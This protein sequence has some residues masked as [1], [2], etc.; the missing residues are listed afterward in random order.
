VNVRQSEKKMERER[1]RCLNTMGPHVRSPT[2]G[3]SKIMGCS[4][5]PQQEWTSIVSSPEIEHIFG[6]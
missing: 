3:Y 4:F 1:E 6:I 5:A 2:L